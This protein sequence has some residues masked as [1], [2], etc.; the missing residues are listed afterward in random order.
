MRRALNLLSVSLSVTL[1]LAGLTLS[2]CGGSES[3]SGRDNERRAEPE[4]RSDKLRTN[5]PV[6]STED[7]ATFATDNLA[8]SVD[9]H[10]ELRSREPG[11]FVFSQ[12]SI[13]TALAMLYAGAATTTSDE[14]AD[15]LHFS[16]PAPR[17]HA[18]FNALDLALTTSPPGTSSA[19]FRLEVANSIWV[20]DGL[21]I[22]FPRR[23][24]GA[25]QEGQP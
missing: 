14:M 5:A 10:L 13:S 25:I 21:T 19:A 12:T 2:G 15:A 3:S 23:L 8:F 4:L 22:L 1:L 16:L 24:E 18:A 9:M 7:A 6:I 11:N 20:Q 17:L